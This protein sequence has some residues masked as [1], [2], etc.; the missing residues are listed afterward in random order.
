MPIQLEEFLI[1]PHSEE[2]SVKCA[3]FAQIVSRCGYARLKALGTSMAPSILPGDTLIVERRQMP[4]LAIGDV[5]VYLRSGRLFAHRVARI[6]NGPDA[7]LVTRGDA[8]DSDDPPVLADE[9]IGRVVSVVPG[10]RLA[11]RLRRLLAAL[12]SAMAIFFLA[13]AVLLLLQA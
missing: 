10:P 4:G 7:T 3:L 1:G 11:Y 13:G 5:A 8:M 12:R 2:Q 6:V 9:I